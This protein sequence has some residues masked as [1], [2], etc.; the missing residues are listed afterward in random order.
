VTTGNWFRLSDLD[1][2]VI[3]RAIDEASA[4]LIDMYDGEPNPLSDDTDGEAEDAR[5]LNDARILRM[6][7][8]A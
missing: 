4:F 2:D 1:K 7:L 6:R 5:W 8:L 3:V